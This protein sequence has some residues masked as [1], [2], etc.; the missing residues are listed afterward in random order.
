MENVNVFKH[1]SIK[2]INNNLNI[3]IDPFKIDI[4]NHDASII[5]ITHSHYDHF[6]IEDILK[7]KNDNTKIVSTK[8]TYSELLK[9]FKEDDIL[10]VEP[11]GNYDIL[12]IN[13]STVRAYN[14]NK[15]FHPISNDWVGYILILSDKKY[16]I[17]GD[18]DINEDI[19]NIKCDV[20]FIP[21]GGTYTMDYKEAADYTNKISPNVVIPTHYGLIVGDKSLGAKFNNL[22]NPNI[23][24][25]L[26]IK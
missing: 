1:N 24:C 4:D 14:V 2:I 25:E 12:G 3:Y 23:K 6:S 5:F 9:Y 18:T 8:D 20:L 26:Y 16:Y 10:I 19:L 21:I 22:V 15:D 11:N 13:F 17:M 7:I